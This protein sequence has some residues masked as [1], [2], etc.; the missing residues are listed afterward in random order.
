MAHGGD[1]VYVFISMIV[2]SDSQGFLRIAP[3]ALA[4]RIDKPLEVIEVSLKALES[5]DAYSNTAMYEGKRIISLKELT[6]GKENRGWWIVNKE[7]FKYKGSKE[8]KKEKDRTRIKNKRHVASSRTPSLDV[9]DVA[10]T[11]TDINTTIVSP[12]VETDH[13]RL[14]TYFG[15]GFQKTTGNKWK[16]DGAKDGALLKTLLSTFSALE[17]KELIDKFF[18]SEDEFIKQAGKSFGIFYSMVNKLNSSKKE[19]YAIT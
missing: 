5:P 11:D 1:T 18:K 8:E 12:K 9:A 19:R 15:K 13:F 17:V 10:Y 3:A 6:N 14:I 7:Q 2:L 4:K 16:M